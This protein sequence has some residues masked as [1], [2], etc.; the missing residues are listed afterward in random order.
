MKRYLP[1]LIAI[2]TGLIMIS[3]LLPGMIPLKSEPEGPMPTMET[4]ANAVIKTLSAPGWHY[5]DALVKEK[6]SSEVFAKPG[7]VKFTANITDDEPVY[8]TYGWC[9]VD[10]ATLKQNFEHITVKLY[11]NGEELGEDVVH[12]LTY[13]SSDNMACLDHGVLTSNWPDGN[14]DLKA[15]ATFDEK[16]N[17]GLDDYEPGD[18]IFEYKVSVNKQAEGGATP[19]P[20]NPQNGI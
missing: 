18:Y 12:Q 14:Y 19:T 11:I 20:V 4:D 7:T 5:L 13:T 1:F 2:A 8:F 9:A 6:Y 15:V 16:L 10:D 17:D 3:C